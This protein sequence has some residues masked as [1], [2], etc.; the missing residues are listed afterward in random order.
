MLKHHLAM[1]SIAIVLFLVS[2]G[3]SE[4]AALELFEQRIMPIFRS[5][6]PSSCVQCHLASVDLKDY[7]LPSHEQTFVSLRDQG[8]VDVT[9]PDKSKI[10]VLIQMGEKDRDTGAKLIHSKIRKAEHDAFAAWIKACCSDDRLRRLPAS[11][12]AKLAKPERPEAVIRHNRKDRVLDSFVRNV[13][14]QRMRCFPC[15]TPHELDSENPQHR[16]P[17]ERH[18]EFEKKYGQRIN[19]FRETPEATMK[20]LIASSRKKSSKRLPLLNYD[21]PRKSLLV[22]KPTSKLPNKNA[23]GTFD[24]PS[25]LEPV[26]HMGGLKMHVDDQSYKSFVT[27]I[28]D[29]SRVAND[30][31][32]SAQSLPSDNWYPSKHVLRIKDTPS[33]WP[34]AST[35]QLF[36]HSWDR[37]KESW[38]TEPIAFTQGTITPR[39]F[40][41]GMLF[42]LAPKSSEQPKKW[43]AKGVSLEPGKYLIKAYL[44]KT[45]RLAKDPTQLLGLDDFVGQ[46]EIQ[47]RW[48]EGFREAEIVAGEKL[49]P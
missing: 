18:R 6:N 28:Q 32:T 10:L 33:A 38:V 27:W 22:M 19:I 36:V 47:A 40:I 11:T 3:V 15:H 44:D 24:P 23:S 5:P 37:K 25:S 20:A 14:S 39:Q 31:Y 16:V 30:Q 49:K 42:L 21:E 12:D 26:S 43:S 48:N 45:G 7:I 4:D 17:T 2:G 13:W 8:L 41:N 9:N 1:R 29:Y 34:I 35:V 46:A